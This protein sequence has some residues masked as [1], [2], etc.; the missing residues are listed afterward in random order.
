MYL[1]YFN[2]LSK[3]YLL[4]LSRDVAQHEGPLQS[5]RAPSTTTAIHSHILCWPSSHEG[6]LYSVPYFPQ[7]YTPG[8][9]P[10]RVFLLY[11][12]HC[13]FLYY[14]LMIVYAWFLWRY[15][16][17]SLPFYYAIACMVFQRKKPSGHI[18]STTTA[19]HLYIDTLGFILQ[20]PQ[21]NI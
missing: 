14:C 13:V 11:I 16:S 3:G 17:G 20:S 6:L 21:K 4:V 2:L 18:R 15:Q 5:L 7:S 12:V 9:F 1:I 8:H 19:A 10:Q